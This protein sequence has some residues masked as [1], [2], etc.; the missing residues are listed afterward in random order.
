[1]GFDM[2]KVKDKI[3]G[4]NQTFHPNSDSKGIGLFLVHNHVTSLGG[5]I[6]V[7]SM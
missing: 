3:F 7:K 1:M 2:D 4:F 6:S 5:S